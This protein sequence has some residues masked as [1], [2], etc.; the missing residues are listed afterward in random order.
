MSSATIQ[1]GLGRKGVVSDDTML[2]QIAKFQGVNM[3]DPNNPVLT[4]GTPI[5]AVLV[6]NDS[7]GTVAS[8]LGITYKSGY[9]G[10]RIGALS[11]AN[12]ICHGVVDPFL[13]AGVTVANGETCWVILQG[14]I[15]VEIG[16]GDIG[17]NDI[18]QTL[19]N[20][21]FGT[22]T[23]GTNPIGHCGVA[24]EAGTSTNRARVVFRNAFA[25]IAP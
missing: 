24:L 17:A 1:M 3:D 8:G 16:A 6:K 18:V 7:G 13:G 15:D 10:T 12:A 20:G 22:G 4:S 9:V 19:A 2:G 23:A 5:Y 14:D 25:P 11:G 21:K